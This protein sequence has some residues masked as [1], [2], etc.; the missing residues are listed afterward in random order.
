MSKK[1]Q[2]FIKF[3]ITNI[4]PEPSYFKSKNKRSIDRFFENF[5]EKEIIEIKQIIL[6]ILKNKKNLEN[7]KSLV[8]LLIHTSHLK[9]EN[10]KEYKRNFFSQLKNL[11]EGFFL[12]NTISSN[13]FKKTCND[14]Y[15]GF[16]R[17]LKAET[18]QTTKVLIDGKLTRVFVKNWHGEHNY[19]MGWNELFI[20][21]E[22]LNVYAFKT[23]QFGKITDFKK[24]IDFKKDSIVIYPKSKKIA[25]NF[26]KELY[27]TIKRRYFKNK[28]PI[29]FNRKKVVSPKI[30]RK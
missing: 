22:T 20:N 18:L 21:P 10:K 29:C 15:A 5:N 16:Y 23:D 14:T 2:E 19:L 8:N 1:H 30:K 13:S 24:K 7:K 6:D 9:L 25:I 28:K 12:H 27:E 26:R 11:K 4:T 17:A 3:L